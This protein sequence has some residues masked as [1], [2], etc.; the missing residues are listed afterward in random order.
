MRPIH[1][2]QKRRINGK[3]SPLWA[4][5]RKAHLLRQP[6]CQMCGGDEEL[7]VHHIHPF[8]LHPELELD[9][10]NLITLCEKPGHDCHFIMGHFHN[11][12]AMNPS[13]VA[14]AASYYR[15]QQE[16]H[17]ALTRPVVDTTER[18]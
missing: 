11:W 10:G 7:Q 6:L 12:R 2:I 17:H 4:R 18:A 15:A 16:A 3:R 9:Q 13:V 8:H 14:D 5:T 1:A